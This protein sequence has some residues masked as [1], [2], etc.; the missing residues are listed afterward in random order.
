MD[1]HVQEKKVE[2]LHDVKSNVL[3]KSGRNRSRCPAAQQNRRSETFL[4]KM[5]KLQWN[6]RTVNVVKCGFI[7]HTSGVWRKTSVFLNKAFK[8]LNKVIDI[9]RQHTFGCIATTHVGFWHSGRTSAA[10]CW[11]LNKEA[12]LVAH[13]RLQK[14]FRFV[15]TSKT[16]SCE[17]SLLW[18]SVDQKSAW[19]R[20]KS[21]LWV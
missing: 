9:N 15:L 8:H 16:F 13:R 10:K 7:D 1:P 14:D 18:N 12:L 19:W 4:E 17:G 6:S 2:K 20:V 3:I 21:Q 5:N 11:R